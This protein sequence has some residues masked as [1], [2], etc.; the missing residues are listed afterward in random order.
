MALIRFTGPTNSLGISSTNP[1]VLQATEL[2]A[3]GRVIGGGG[4]GDGAQGPMGNPGETGPAGADGQD[5][6]IGVYDNLSSAEQ[7]AV[8]LGQIVIRYGRYWGVSST[9]LARVNGPLDIPNHGWSA[10]SGQ[11]RG[12][13]PSASRTYDIGDHTIVGAGLTTGDEYLCLV[14]GSY[15]SAQIAASTNWIRTPRN[16]P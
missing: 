15:T 11:N 8:E 9:A 12:L 2:D 16:I 14:G 6:V 3:E 13:A 5:A 4:S 1:V 7:S 10:L